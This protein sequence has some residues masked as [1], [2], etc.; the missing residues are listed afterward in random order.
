MAKK[1]KDTGAQAKKP[2]KLM[3]QLAGKDYRL[4]VTT[5]L[6]WDVAELF[7]GYLPLYRM[8]SNLVPRAFPPLL[9]LACPE[10]QGLK[11]EELK[12]LVERSDKL[13]ISYALI[14]LLDALSK[15]AD[16][17]TP[18]ELPPAGSQ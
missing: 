10:L 13:K 14:A 17:D 16:D 9:R 5:A 6:M 2:E 8:L 15:P 1:E 12:V 11:D 7:D 3:V 18:G 4:V